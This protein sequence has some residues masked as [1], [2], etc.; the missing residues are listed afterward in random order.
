MNWRLSPRVSLGG[1][2]VSPD[3]AERQTATAAEILRRFDHLPG[4]VLA[5]EVGMGKTFVALAVAA[6]VIEATGGGQVVV[7]VPRSVGRKWPK[8]WRKFSR[9]LDDG[10]RAVNDPVTSASEFL[11]L[12][13]DPPETRKHLIVLTHGALTSRLADPLLKLAILRRAFLRCPRLAQQRKVL[14]RWTSRVISQA[15]WSEEVSAALLDAPTSRWRTILRRRTGYDPG[16]DPVPAAFAA[17]LEKADVVALR[18]VLAILPLRK[19]ASLEQ[20]LREVRRQLES[21]FKDTWGTC[22]RRL[23]LRLPLLILDEAHHAKNRHTRLASLFASEESARADEQALKAGELSDIFERMLFLTATPFQLGH[24]ELLEVLRRF[25]GIRWDGV[26]RAAYRQR[27][28]ELSVALDAARASALRL[29]RH[30]GRIRPQDLVGAPDG[31]WRDPDGAPDELRSVA[32]AW[33][34]AEGRARE[35]E[36]RL[37]PLVLRHLR[38]DREKR[39]DLLCGGQIALETRD[40]SRGLAVAGPAVL[41]FLLAARAQA[42]VAAQGLRQ[43]RSARAI[44]ADGLASSFEAYR[45][46][47]TTAS[48]AEAAD[49]VDVEEQ[50]LPADVG[51]YLDQ[52]SAA[53]PEE[54]PLHAE[55]PKVRATVARTLHLWREREK[56]LV[57]CFYRATGR[58][59]RRHIAQAIA[60]ETTTRA[61]RMLGTERNAEETER[62]L[63]R[64][65][66][67]L[68]PSQ[69]GRAYTVA[70]DLVIDALRTSLSGE[71][72][73]TTADLCLRFLRTSSFLVR[74]VDL[75]RPLPEALHDAFA[76][77]DASG[78]S[79]RQVVEAFGAFVA[80][81]EAGERT[82]YL[83]ALTHVEVGDIGVRDDE[84][85]RETLTPAVRLVNGAVKPEQRERLMLGFNTPFFPDVL[86]ASAVM[87]E[88]VDLHLHCRHVIHHD[89]DWNP[90]TIEQRTGRLDRIGSKGELVG[91]PILVFE[92]FIEATQDEK[93]FRVMKDR[94]RWFN[95]V[96]G[97]KLELDEW[98]TDRI[99]GRVE[100]PEGAAA[101]L[102][103]D[104][105]V[106]R[107]TATGTSRGPGGR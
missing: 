85:E 31:W 17:A 15:W 61:A 98:S 12:L 53:L 5:D 39:R 60:A 42:L 27:L 96:M 63:E 25:E 44:F 29:D 79:F 28:E 40:G 66:R 88:G 68:E 100:L 81:R 1:P 82:D 20:R 80:S 34:D 19:S 74:Y 101:P 72:L 84:G 95:V 41:P 65:R 16:D 77:R 71:E 91:R 38:P 86:I 13:D 105:A 106:W 18:D 57:F 30:W 6:S 3:V 99:A 97:A 94:E 23:D 83:D 52:I 11:K 54:G 48:I 92:P 46:T 14:P 62:R 50:E 26:D 69:A 51:W 76:Q 103:V 70:H 64:A 89:L 45:Q 22:L 10:I 55:H 32:A 35:A 36:L 8:E 59:L 87:A 78:W 56:V 75:S 43:H 58:A 90:S 9:G 49:D 21:E 24:H 102:G 4:Q 2:D 7:M 107:Q 104:L 47:R 73:D 33:V 67:N 93:V 37:R